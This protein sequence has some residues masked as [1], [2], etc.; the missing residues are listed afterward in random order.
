MA[1]WTGNAGAQSALPAANPPLQRLGV[2]H[3]LSHNSVLSVA[4]DHSGFLWFGTLDG[5]NRYDGTSFRVH[6]ADPTD[7]RSLPSSAVLALLVDHD[8]DIWIGTR[9]GL[10]RLGRDRRSFERWPLRGTSIVA[11]AGPDREPSVEALLET[12]TGDVWVAT[13]AGLYRIEAQLGRDASRPA[14]RITRVLEA[15]VYGLGVDPTGTPWAI[16]Y[17]L[18]GSSII[19]RVDGAGSKVSVPLSSSAIFFTDSGTVWLDAEGPVPT[20]SLLS[21]G[22]AALRRRPPSGVTDATTSAITADHDGR[23]WIG[24]Y[25]G[26]YAQDDDGALRRMGTE[27]SNAL[28]N[29][30]TSLLVDRGG[31]VWIG[32]F[33]G[34]LRHDPRRKR[35][36]HFALE[37]GLPALPVSSIVEMPNAEIWVGTY[38]G[39]IARFDERTGEFVAETVQTPAGAGLCDYVWDLQPGDDGSLWIGTEGTLCERHLDGTGRLLALPPSTGQPKN[40]ERFGSDR[41]WMGASSG[42]FVLDETARSYRQITLAADGSP[43]SVDA[44]RVAPDGAV[45]VASGGGDRPG[46]LARYDPTED[47]VA[48]YPDL[49]AEGIWDIYTG[50]PRSTW[51]ATGS[52]LARFQSDPQ[53]L[54]MVASA[55]DLI[56]GFVFSILPDDSGRLWLGTNNGLVRYDPNAG[57]R[58]TSRRFG[59]HDGIENREFNRHA[60]LRDSRGRM[61]FGG[62]SG[63]TMFDPRDISDNSL[64]PAMAITAITVLEATGERSIAPSDELALGP[65]THALTL[66]FA[67]LDFTDPTRNRYQYQLEG[68]DPGW[69]DNGTRR[70]VR[71]TNLPAGT[72]VFRV[73]GTNN[74]GVWSASEATQRLVVHPAIWQTLWF[75]AALLLT[76]VATLAAAYGRRIHRVREL[77]RMRLRIA[78]DLHDE[79]A[80]ELAAISLLSGVLRQRA[81]LPTADRDSLDD[82]GGTSRRAIETLRDIVWYVTPEHDNLG[83]MVARMR[84]TAERLLINIEHTIQADV[85]DAETVIDMNQ[86]REIM[87]AYKELLHN[88]VRHAD[89]SEVEIELRVRP[90]LFRMSIRD[91]GVGFAVDA[92]SDGTGLG[93]VRRRAAK[94][95]G[96][97]RISSQPKRGTSVEMSVPLAQTRRGHSRPTSVT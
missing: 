9:R 43:Y 30:A 40:L 79:I 54:E 14:P 93:S 64:P 87:L 78:G 66:E 12:D 3:G 82:I 69:L 28:D 22:G 56:G 10:A 38:G 77:E 11:N 4:Q 2:E 95:G 36:R 42:L 96:E 62:M 18:D 26:I 24:T 83:S 37:S 65:D 70:S 55:G 27:A 92:S 59:S 61:W 80:S 32:T 21:D 39:G 29:E 19:Q 81:Y 73:R 52:G 46:T 44:L 6:R 53:H 75:R 67:A 68:V 72:F 71:Y 47:T 85:G 97:L 35:F 51:L 1:A 25:R 50:D 15:P 84:R 76:T 57:P 23:I 88:I 5:L 74:D 48:L 17:D 7:E 41:L 94:I 33:N 60:A 34:V 8:D 91:N 31:T 13:T 45:W 20:S 86:R 58:G 89:A 16:T 90:E 49:I 63:L